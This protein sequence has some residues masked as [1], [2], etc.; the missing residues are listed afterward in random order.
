MKTSKS[1]RRVL[2]YAHLI[3]QLV[4]PDYSHPNS[5]RDYTQPQLFACLVLKEFLRLDYR[6]LNGLLKDSPDL[7]AAIDLDKNPHF[8]IPHFTTFQKAAARLLRNRHA[9]RYLDKTIRLAQVQR[10][11]PRRVSL[12]ALDGTGLETRHASSYYVKRRA[13][14]GKNWHRTT[15]QRFPKA[16]VLCDTTTHLVLAVVPERGPGS[17]AKHFRRALG[18][19]HRRVSIQTLAADAGY[20]GEHLHRFAHDHGVR[21]L[22]P[23]RIGRPTSKP[24]S[25]YWRRQMKSRLHLTR[26]TQRWQVETVNSMLKRLLGSALRARHYWSQCREILLRAITLNIMILR[27]KVFY[28]AGQVQSC[29]AL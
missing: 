11:L 6:K 9:Q 22:I 15:Y 29:S 20:D 24:P 25:G 10:R 5:R 14:N 16:G 26:Y 21:S 3:G 1:P 23:P 4:L 17:D 18:E 28:R 7:A 12:A 27:A 8:K 2:Q 13:N 19:A